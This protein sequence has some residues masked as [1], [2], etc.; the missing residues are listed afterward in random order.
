MSGYTARTGFRYQDLYLLFRVL[1]DASDSLDQAWQNGAPEVLQVLD[2]KAVRYGIEAS[3]R[4][5]GPNCESV[6]VGPDWDVLV[7]T[8]GKLEFAEVKSGA[9]AKDDRLVFWKR[10]RRE[11]ASGSMDVTNIVPVLVVDP[12][13]AGDL[14]KW[15]ELAAAASRFS[16]TLPSVEPTNNVLTTAQLL[17]EALWC[18]CQPDSSFSK[19]DP[20]VT[21]AV[22]QGT[23][24]RFELHRHGAQQLDS[25]VSQLVELLFPGGLADTE[26]TLLMGWLSERAT[27]STQGRRLFTIRELL[28]E[29]GIL[30]HAASLATGTLREWRDLWNEVPQGVTARTHLQLGEA[31]ESVPAAKVQPAALE[32]LT[33]G[34]NQAFVIL[35][36]GGAG[37]STFLAQAARAATQRGDVVLHCGADD[38]NPEELEKLVKAF[39]FRAAVAAIKNP[40][41]RACI[42]VDGLDEAEPALR[43]RWGQLLVRLTALPNASLIAS[44]REAVWN[45]DGE[46]RK[47][48][49]VWPCVTLALWP[50]KLIHDLLM[51]TPYRENLPSTVISL[52]RTPILLDLFWRTFV[53]TEQHDLSLAAKLQTRHNLLAAYWGQ[54]LM[55]SPRYTSV[56]EL[57]LRLGGILSQVAGQIGPFLETQLDE[58]VLHVLLSEGVFVEEGRLQRRLRFRHPLLRDFSFA[59]WCLTTDDATQVSN[60]WN[61]IRGGLQRYGALRAVFEALSDPDAQC[62]YPQLELG[63]V[64]QAIVRTDSNLSAQVA[65]VLGTHKPSPGLDPAKWPTEVQSSLP[66][67]FGHELLS[68]ARLAQNGSWAPIVE[69]WPN[70]AAW[71][72]ADYPQE[73][74]RYLSALLE[75]RKSD[76]ANRELLEQCRQAARKLRQISEVDRF[77]ADFSNSDRW[78]KMH[79][80]TCVIPTLPDEVT[81]SWVER[82]MPYSSWRTRSY[83]LERLVY[84]A[85]VNLYRTAAVYRQAVGLIQEDGHHKL[86]SAWQ[87]PVFDHHAIEWSLAGEG[88]RRGLLKEH[89]V[90]FLPVALELAE[91]LWHA[92]LEDR[93]STTNSIS[94]LIREFDPS[95]TEEAAAADECRLK[96]LLGD[97]IDDSPEWSYWRGFPDHDVQV[98]CLGA[99]HE[100]A[101]RCAKNALGNFISSIVPSLRFSR[102]ASV[103]SILLDVLLQQ[104]E[105][106]SCLDCVIERLTDSRLYYTSGIEYWLEQGLIVGWPHAQAA[107]RTKIF[108]IIRALLSTPGEEHNAK[109]FLLRLP[110][111]DLPEDLRNERPAEDDPSHHPYARPHRTG[112]T[113]FKGVPIAEEDE[114]VIGQWPEGFDLDLLLR[115]SRATKEITRP[116]TQPEKLRE[117]IVAAFEAAVLLTEI[118]RNRPDLLQDFKRTWVL[119]S[120]TEML[121]AARRIFS[122]KEVPPEELIRNCAD[123]ALAELKD[124]PSDLSGD[125]KDDGLSHYNE[126]PWTNALKL[127]DAVLTWPPVASDQAIQNEFLKIIADAFESGHPMVQFVCTLLI[128]PWHWFRNSERRLLHD[129]LVWNLPRH[130]SVLASS[131]G[132]THYYSD[133]DRVRVLRLLL[134]RGDVQNPKHLAHWLGH[135]VGVGSMV[136]FPDGQ[137]SAVSDLARETIE[138]PENFVILRDDT[139]WREFLRQFV[140]GMKEQAKHMSARTE[141]AADY[142]NWAFKAWQ[143]LRANRQRRGESE[144]VVLISLHWLEKKERKQAEVGQKRVW[145]QHLQ[146]LL[147]SIVTDG[148]RPDCFT[149]FFN[150]RDGEYND[151]TTPEELMRLGKTYAERVRKGAQDGSMKLDEIDQGLQEWN[152]WRES[153]DYLAETVDT[154]RGDGSLQTDLQREQAH[155]LLSQLASEPVRSSKAI[156]VLHRLQ[157]E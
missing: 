17:D 91:A 143:F 6:A 138:N 113:S 132:K 58:E 24:G 16:C 125:L 48:L 73:V 66:V 116:G 106:A 2:K 51:P 141:L 41:I 80:M 112:V 99:I 32:V 53:E 142:G 117:Q 101:E 44:I 131:L 77:A 61:S 109:N 93:S 107:E 114:R 137:R 45:G 7:L 123:V 95:L 1:R 63:N 22:A 64:V 121:D 97:L 103:H 30:E 67:N 20:A 94:K 146:P 74:W 70:E 145:W 108:E 4:I 147:E 89:P 35:G 96:A 126:T 10:L 151:L 149:L 50:E 12:D 18:L 127:A 75:I 72:G 3:P 5:D 128:R 13:K 11:L 21:L 122:D 155:R 88:E 82:E 69:H 87:G 133:A 76:S 60:R 31:G 14:T 38:V 29:I 129:R 92:K 111:D 115:F 135:Y 157:N 119:Q 84:L 33:S 28:A 68:A 105:Q 83:V 23:L 124:G 40:D 27:A 79:A 9:I 100:C 36:Q 130:A 43:K 8:R 104:R 150:L 52:I 140:F 152:S 134:N 42:F 15:Q 156:E 98:R 85:P 154:L 90:T 118:L 55:H 25:N 49:Q 59:Q 136:V 19:D 102:L 57:P 86:A 26:Q 56:R 110:L 54:R 46:L 81:L 62:E 139:N 71:I 34:K 47:E 78:L 148:G 39:R 144:N 120:L 153:A 65:Q 37:K